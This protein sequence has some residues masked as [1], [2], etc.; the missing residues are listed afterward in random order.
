MMLNHLLSLP[1]SL[2]NGMAEEKHIECLQIN[3]GIE[4]T[5]RR[6]LWAQEENT[7]VNKVTIMVKEENITVKEDSIMVIMVREVDAKV[8]CTMEIT[9]NMKM[10]TRVN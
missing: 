2:K 6:T 3:F 1:L 7:I 5:R 4:P 10:I 9:I 8:R